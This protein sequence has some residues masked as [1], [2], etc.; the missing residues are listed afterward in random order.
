M[1]ASEA[2]IIL[3]KT[4]D[5]HRRHETRRSDAAMIAAPAAM[6]RFA[7]IPPASR[8]HSVRAGLSGADR[9]PPHYPKKLLQPLIPIQAPCEIRKYFPSVASTQCV[10]RI[11]TMLPHPKNI[12]RPVSP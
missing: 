3:Q 9:V 10:K 6:C 7:P 11:V 1:P 12:S 2:K 5:D 8:R 4:Q